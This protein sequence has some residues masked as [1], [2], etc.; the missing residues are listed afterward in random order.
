MRILLFSGTG[1]GRRLSYRLRERGAEVTVCVATEYG[2]EEQGAASGIRVLTGPRTEEEKQL[3]LRDADFCVDA[4]HPYAR[5]VSA[6][7]REAC[8]KSGVPCLRLRRESSEAED[9]VWV[10]DAAEAAGL[11]AVQPGNVL[12]TTGTRDLAA[13]SGLDPSRL[14]PRVLPT[15]EALSACEALGIPH[16]NVVAMH[17]PFSRDLNTA[18]IRQYDI[19]ILVTKDGGKT[20]GFPEKAE[21]AKDCGTELIV[22]RRPQET[23]F[24]EEE[25]LNIIFKGE[26]E[27]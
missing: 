21:A 19:R 5:H 18:L 22:L 8:R 14:F 6:S 3:L 2:Q 7:V 27:E 13:F 11:L 4:T 1:D 10:A 23:G 15:H 9:A 26:K 17:G 25:I 20:G 24:S 16:R 12:L